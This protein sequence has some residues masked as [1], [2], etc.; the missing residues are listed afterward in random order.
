MATGACLTVYY[1]I[2]VGFHFGARDRLV[3][4]LPAIVL[5]VAAVIVTLIS[6]LPPA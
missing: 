2:A 4:A 1:V 6:F 5:L 3:D